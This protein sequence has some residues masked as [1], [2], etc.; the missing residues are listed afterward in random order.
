LLFSIMEERF[1][2]NCGMID[3]EKEVSPNQ[4]LI[5]RTD[6]SYGSRIHMESMD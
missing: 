1:Y 3:L 4:A 5:R 6:S 2:S